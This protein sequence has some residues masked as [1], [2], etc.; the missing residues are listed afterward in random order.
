M[1]RRAFL[2][3]LETA[4][5]R[6]ASASAIAT[7][8]SLGAIGKVFI[9]QGEMTLGAPTERLGWRQ[10]AAAGLRGLAGKLR[11]GHVT[12]GGLSQTA[13]RK[14]QASPKVKSSLAESST[15]T[16][17]KWPRDAIVSLAFAICQS[18]RGHHGRDAISD[19]DIVILP[20]C[21]TR[22][23]KRELYT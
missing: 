14:C 8:F 19:G 10:L 6:I 18:F 20:L 4:A 15:L 7:R 16:A 5:A 11:H 23:C 2:L 12:L 9:I 21:A 3:T 22:L 17:E 13:F 1:Q